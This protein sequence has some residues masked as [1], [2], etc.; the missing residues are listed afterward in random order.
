MKHSFTFKKKKVCFRRLK[1]HKIF[2]RRPLRPITLHLRCNEH[3]Y[4]NQ[5]LL[6][7]AGQESVRRESFLSCAPQHSYPTA[8][9]RTIQSATS[10]VQN[11][12]HFYTIL[13]FWYL[14]IHKL[15]K[16][17]ADLYIHLNRQSTQH[18]KLLQAPY[19]IQLKR[20]VTIGTIT[21][22]TISA[23]HINLIYTD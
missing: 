6:K 9:H 23:W 8:Q 18:K 22:C 20:S 11:R 19:T 7:Q 3:Q 15:S 16:S 13:K 12:T 5:D 2:Y 10:H 4:K 17:L 1:N 21:S 14:N